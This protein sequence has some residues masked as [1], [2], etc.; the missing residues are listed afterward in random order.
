MQPDTNPYAP[1]TSA[2]KTPPS[3]YRLPNL[4]RVYLIGSMVWIAGRAMVGLIPFLRYSS[5]AFDTMIWAWLV[6]VI[7]TLVASLA[8]YAALLN[9]RRWGWYGLLVLT[10]F[11]IATQLWR[12]GTIVSFG[13]LL[14][15]VITTGVLFAGGTNKAWPHLR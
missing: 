9:V 6:M 4:L 5:G 12:M 8:C 14:H 7:V 15:F 13:P 1:L 10:A 2:V 11:G 3:E